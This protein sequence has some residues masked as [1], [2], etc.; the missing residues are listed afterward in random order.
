MRIEK[1]IKFQFLIG[2]LG[3]RFYCLLLHL[4]LGFNSLQVGQVLYFYFVFYWVIRSFNSLQVGQVLYMSFYNLFIIFSFNSL[5]V[6]QVLCTNV[7]EISKDYLF[8]FLIGRLGTFPPLQVLFLCPSFNSLQV[9]QVL[10]S[11]LRTIIL[12][13]VSI[14]YRQARYRQRK[15]QVRNFIQGFNSL[16]VGQVLADNP[17]LEKNFVWFQ[18]LIGRLGTFKFLNIIFHLWKVSIP[19]RQARYVVFGRL[20]LSLVMRFNSLQ[21]GQVPIPLMRYYRV[22]ESFNSLQVGQVPMKDIQLIIS[23]IKV[24]I[25]YRQ[26]RYLPGQNKT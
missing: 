18:F 15:Y 8:Q 24:S 13:Y 9:G 21:V 3:T 6:G 2:R 7:N 20:R 12:I 23:M 5:Q 19:Y 10:S 4:I 26:A 17:K 1:E 25:P 14:P 22:F 11:T 16:Q